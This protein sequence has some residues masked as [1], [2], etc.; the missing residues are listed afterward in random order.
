MNYDFSILCNEQREKLSKRLESLNKSYLKE[1][2]IAL[3]VINVSQDTA[4]DRNVL[5]LQARDILENQ[6]S[7]CEVIY[8]KAF[9]EIMELLANGL[10]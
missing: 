10:K 7:R 5:Y 3:N 4:Q 8:Q 6:V 2:L 9:C 1:Y